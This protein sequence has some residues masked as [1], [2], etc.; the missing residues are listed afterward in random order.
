MKSR[1][2]TS[3]LAAAAGLLAGALVIL[4]TG[5]DP[6]AAYTALAYGAMGSGYGWSEVAVKSCPLI[7]TGLAVALAFRAGLWNIGVEGQL[8]GGAVLAVFFA[9]RTPH[10]P[11]I[12]GVPAT[13]LAAATGGALIAGIAAILKLERGVDEVISTIM[14]NF[15]VLG[16]VGYLVHGPLMESSGNYPQS[17]ALPTFARLPRLFSGYRVH[18]GLAGALALVPATAFVLYRTRFG[19]VIRAT[20]SNPIATKIAGFAVD[21]CILATFV[22]SGA[23]AGLA[24][25]MEVA[26]VTY[27]MYDN[28]S[29]GYGYT[30]I[31]VAILGRLDPW[32]VL[33]AALM[34]GV[35]EAGSASM[36]RVAGVSAVLVSLIQACVIF[37]LAAFEYQRASDR[38]GP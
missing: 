35:L 5:G 11:S 18:V 16:V 26:S 30:A 32:G 7:V 25:G 33:A 15:I 27:R 23:L 4:L 21:R 28:F 8:V 34:F 38:G 17:D 37:A 12:I 1:A 10:L 31:A 36:Q 9:T 19:Y 6:I 14:L 2:I 20:G 29:P 24:G 13:L 3:V 22:A